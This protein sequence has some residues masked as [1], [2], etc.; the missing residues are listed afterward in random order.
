MLVTI[1]SEIPYHGKT[2]TYDY[3]LGIIA[4][5][6]FASG[7]GRGGLLCTFPIF[8]VV[9]A[10]HPVASARKAGGESPGRL[11]RLRGI[12]VETCRRQVASQH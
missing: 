3:V 9:L 12:V 7:N 11:N 6:F 1:G 4:V 8:A 10:T 2:G 5:R